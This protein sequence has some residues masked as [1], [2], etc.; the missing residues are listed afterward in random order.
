MSWFDAVEVDQDKVAAPSAPADTRKGP[1]FFNWNWDA[2]KASAES[3]FWDVPGRAAEDRAT[4][5]NMAAAELAQLRGGKVTDYHLPTFQNPGMAP[6]IDEARFWRDLAEVRKTRPHALADLGKDAADFDARLRRGYGEAAASRSERMAKGGLGGNLLGGI[7]GTF[8]DPVNLLTLPLGASP[9]G[10]GV[11]AAARMVLTEG[12]IN[13]GI[14]LA[15]TPGFI[16]E[17]AAQGRDWTAEEMGTNVALAGIGGAALSA[18][19]KTIG[20]GIGAAGRAAGAVLDRVD[21][22]RADRALAELFRNSI[23]GD[24]ALTPQQAAALHVLER[25]TEVAAASPFAHTYAAIEAHLARVDEALRNAALGP[26]PTAPVAAPVD[27]VPSTGREVGG[28]DMSRYLGRTRSA[29]SSGSDTAAAATSSAY[30][31]YQFLRETWLSYYAKTFGDTGES[32]AEILAKRANG[33]T[34]D[35]VM[36][37]FTEA[38]VR[39]LRRAGVPVNDATV[40]LAHFLGAGDAV[41]VLKASPDAPL[42]GLLERGTIDANRAVFEKAGS[43]SELVAWAHAKMG[44]QAGSVPAKPGALDVT[45]PDGDLSSADI[46]AVPVVVGMPQPV[47]LE[48]EVR[49]EALQD[50]LRTAL[51]GVLGDRSISLN[52]TAELADD[53]GVSESELRAALDGLVGTGHLRVSK[54]GQYRRVPTAINRGPLTMTQF[55]ARN[56]GL[57]YDGLSENGRAL[58]TR[59]HDLRNSGNLAHFVPAHGPLLRPNGRGLDEMGELLHDAGYFGPPATTPRPTDGELITILDD[60]IRKGEKRY[61]VFDQAPEPKQA[62]SR[63]DFQS[64]EHYQYERGRY[65]RSAQ[66]VLGRALSDDEFD[67]VRSIQLEDHFRGTEADQRAASADSAWEDGEPL[68]PY[69]RELVNREIMDALDDAFLEVEDIDY[70]FFPGQFDDAAGS[71]ARGADQGG[72]GSAPERGDAGEGGARAGDGAGD[73]SGGQ[74]SPAELDALEAAGLSGTPQ[75]HD[76]AHQAFDDPAGDGAR[77]VAESAWH[78]LRAE[79]PGPFGPIFRDVDPGNWK[80]VVARL[81][82][83]QN[84]EVHGALDHPEVGSID[85]VWGEPG[86]GHHDGYGLS[87]ILQYHPEVVEDLPAIIRSM[88]VVSRSD[89]RIKLES[90][91]HRGGIRLDWDGQQKTWLITAFEKNGKASPATEYTRAAVAA[92]AG[93]APAREAGSD[94]RPSG[95]QGNPAADP[96]IAARDRQRAQLGAEA[97]MRASVDQDGTMGSPLFDAADQPT[98]DLGDGKGARTLA[99]I[100]AELNADEAGV[101]AIRSCLL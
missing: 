98:F 28:F 86:T 56:G 82:E 60:V 63:G 53:L 12:L 36:R 20:A 18:T 25:D 33:A 22:T 48:P 65:D 26:R 49:P 97:P 90:A 19:G 38:N 3:A 13:A 96:N 21:P 43:A 92:Q 51:R 88:V 85:V 15:Q 7:A 24:W 70:E 84:G 57:S 27:A 72:V 41:K 23:E 75:F 89:N 95:D 45:A 40:Y 62:G 37:T 16:A 73:A 74:P 94:I 76:S 58:G 68:D 54:S 101:Q 47:E 64:D 10:V 69:V 50:G 71:P 11:K 81:S 44:G 29:E 39:I 91:D 32:K 17:R 66:R 100:E 79:M 83:A 14:E 42:G 46:D 80:A 93:N 30:G 67:A 99:E 59:G 78:D 8:S 6:P 1:G 31:R 52:R 9:A 61:S 2:V 55:I 35:A 4:R 34:Q 5:L 87:K 77:Q